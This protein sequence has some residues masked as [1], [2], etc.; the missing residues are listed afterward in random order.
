MQPYGEQVWAEIGTQNYEM[1]EQ[2]VK[3]NYYGARG[4]AEA[5]APL[6][7]LSDSPRIVNVSSML[8]LLK[9][10]DCLSRTESWYFGSS[11]LVLKFGRVISPLQGNPN[12]TSDWL[13][14]SNIYS[15]LILNYRTFFMVMS[16]NTT[17][18]KHDFSHNPCL[19]YSPLLG[20][21]MYKLFRK[22]K[23]ASCVSS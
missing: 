9:V 1:A 6:L 16:K 21:F 4:M 2:C 5:L 10:H 13:M 12:F 7:Q 3:T 8:G 23:F 11:C 18:R 15:F 19:S 22:C 14:C 20:T 17:P